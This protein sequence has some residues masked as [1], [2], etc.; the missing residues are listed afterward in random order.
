MSCRSVE[1]SFYPVGWDHPILL[2]L[3]VFVVKLCYRSE[4]AHRKGKGKD[5]PTLDTSAGFRSWSRSSAVSPQVTEAI[6]P[7]V[8]CHYFPPDP[9][10]PPQP[11]SFTAHW[12]VPNYTAWWQ[13]PMCVNNFSMVA[14]LSAVAWPG[15]KPATSQDSGSQPCTVTEP[16][17]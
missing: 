5:S 6:N 4:H 13:R 9:R 12:P 10:L 15:F 8:G 11:P 16:R 2:N 14:L 7:A 1:T 3:L 17:V